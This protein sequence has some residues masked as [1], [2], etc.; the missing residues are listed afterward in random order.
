MDDPREL[1]EAVNDTLDFWIRSRVH[2][3]SASMAGGEYAD[4]DLVKCLDRIAP[5]YRRAASPTTEGE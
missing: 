4:V 1:R 5:R 3:I 2:G